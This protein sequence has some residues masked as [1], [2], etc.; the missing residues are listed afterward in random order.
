[1][2][3]SMSKFTTA[4]NGTF[5]FTREKS[6]LD[7]DGTVVSV[8]YCF[9]VTQ[10]N[11]E[12]TVIFL[13][14]NNGIYTTETETRLNVTCDDQQSGTICC[15]KK[16]ISGTDKLDAFTIHVTNTQ[17]LVFDNSSRSE[18]HANQYMVIDNISELTTDSPFTD[19]PVFLL[20]FYLKTCNSGNSDT[21]CKRDEESNI[22]VALI[23]VV[24]V[25]II[26]IVVVMVQQFKSKCH[27]GHRDN[28]RFDI[29][30]GYIH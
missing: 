2:N 26:L 17:L 30:P 4:T 21:S 12:I 16:K 23:L 1:M 27:I 24:L 10:K 15:N 29:A 28:T 14:Q 9:N 6:G 13:I 3:G 19:K 5:F 18:Y 22:I 20:R 7:C 25:V 8:Q 11:D